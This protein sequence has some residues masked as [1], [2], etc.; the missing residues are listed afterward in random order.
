MKKYLILSIL[1]LSF[2]GIFAQNL[3]FS[4]FADPKLSWMSPD[5]KDVSSEGS[6]LGVNIG[7]NVDN[8]FAK[9]YAF[10]TGI[11][12]DNTGGKLKYDFDKKIDTKSS[13]DTIIP[14][15]SILNYKLQ[16][17]NVPLGLKFKT[18][19]IGYTTFFTHLGINGGINIKATGEVDNFE[20]NNENISDEVKLFTLGYF[21]G[22]GVEYSIA[23]NTAIV[24]GITYTNGFIDIT[25]DSNNKVTLS[26]FALR[27]GVLF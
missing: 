15:G 22:A 12:I 3:K 10:M 8:Y 14:A 9:N 18:N 21:I 25:S 7:L 23:G 19:Q 27:L 1:V 13:E 16:Y 2:S 11:S 17:I 4:V 26:N 6:K 24:V 5:L 20:L